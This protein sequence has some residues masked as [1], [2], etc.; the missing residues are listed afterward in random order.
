MTRPKPTHGGKRP[1]AGR[2]EKSPESRKVTLSISV[3][4]ETKRKIAA[5]AKS[6]GVA[7]SSLIENLF[8]S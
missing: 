5:R 2:K 6:E 1:G 8:A 3:L 7:I 4:P